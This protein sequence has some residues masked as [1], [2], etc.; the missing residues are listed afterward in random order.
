VSN[1]EIDLQDSDGVIVSVAQADPT[2]WAGISAQANQLAANAGFSLI[3]GQLFNSPERTLDSIGAVQNWLATQSNVGTVQ[4]PAPAGTDWGLVAIAG[5]AILLTIGA[6][7][8]ALK[9]AG[10]P[11]LP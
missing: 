7:V 9:L 11:R 10:R 5:G 4:K 8:A 3:V 1:L 2:V 6:F